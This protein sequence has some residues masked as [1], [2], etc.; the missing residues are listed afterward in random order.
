MEVKIRELQKQIQDSSE[1][2]IEMEQHW[3]RQQSELVK[4]TREAD[5]QE[6]AVERLNRELLILNQK[7]LRLD[8]EEERNHAG[9]KTHTP[10]P[11]HPTH[12]LLNWIYVW[13]YVHTC[14]VKPY[15]PCYLNSNIPFLF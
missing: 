4:K 12:T 1:S 13:T 7:K 6:T 9:T 11:P 14:I 3:L 8:G 10:H 5:E 2:C 15:S